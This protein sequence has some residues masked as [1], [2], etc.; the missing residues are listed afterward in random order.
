ML[1]TGL[2]LVTGWLTVLLCAGAVQAAPAG[3]H[4]PGGPTQF[5]YLAEQLRKSPVY[6]SDQIPREVP[7]STAPAFARADRCGYRVRAA[8]RGAGAGRPVAARRRAGSGRL[9]VPDRSPASGCCP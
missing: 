4:A 1:R 2:M 6:V 3:P 8:V 5:A 7:R 9:A